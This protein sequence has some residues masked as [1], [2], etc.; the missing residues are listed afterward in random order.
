MNDDMIIKKRIKES[1]ALMMIGD[2]ALV[3]F[4]PCRHVLLWADGPKPWRKAMSPFVKR[5]GLTRMAGA[6]EL[7][8]GLW[9]A[10]R[11]KPRS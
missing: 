3:L 8:L 5:P 11:Q 10:S 7:G 1:I 6:L 2:G 9:L 4:D